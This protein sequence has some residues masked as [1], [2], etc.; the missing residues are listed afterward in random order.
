MKQETDMTIYIYIFPMNIL[1]KNTNILQS[2][3]IISEMTTFFV[4]PNL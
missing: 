1:M 4:N 3:E 2:E